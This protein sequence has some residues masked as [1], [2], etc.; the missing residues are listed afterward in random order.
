MRINQEIL[1]VVH[2]RAAR[3]FELHIG[4]Y[5]PVL[6]YRL[7][8]DTIVFTHTGAPAALEG[9]GVGSFL[10]RAGLDYARRQGYKVIPLCSFVAVYIR[11]HPEYE[12][13]LN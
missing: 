11:R 6:D 1:E 8:D 9:Y 7:Q 3:R 13:L 12:E 2:N 4:E 10:V 5:T